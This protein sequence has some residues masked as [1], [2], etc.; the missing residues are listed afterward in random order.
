M[1]IDV[2]KKIKDHNALHFWSHIIIHHS[3]T[4]DGTSKDW[5]AIRKWHMGLI[6][7]SDETRADYNP[8][9]KNP[10]RDVG[11]N[12]GLEF[13]NGRLEYQEGR[14]MNIDGAHT[15]GMN[16]KALGIC[17][18]GNW[19]TVEPSHQHY[20]LTAC[21]CRELM[22]KFKIPIENV[23]PH[24]AFANKSCPGNKLDMLKLRYEYIENL[25]NIA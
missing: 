18:V 25:K 5:E 16:Q 1:E 22:L 24:W 19:N 13:I 15:L 4:K 17:I 12:W 6:G 8:Y 21:L 2:F 14:S 10:M 23:L 3:L 20:F 9:V 7:S 11:Y